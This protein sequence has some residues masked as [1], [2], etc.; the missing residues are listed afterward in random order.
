MNDKVIS[1]CMATYNGDKYIKEQLDS[2]LMQLSENDELIISDDSSNDNTLNIIESLKDS[3]IKVYR[4][5]FRNVVQNFEFAISKSKGD[6]IFLSDQDDIWHPDKVKE[7][8][9]SFENSNANL[10]ISDLQLIDKHGQ[11]IHQ[12]FFKKKFSSSFLRNLLKNEF[13]GC[14][15]AFDKS[16]K[17][18]ILPFPND[19]PMHDWWIGLIS[20]RNFNV[21]FIEKKLLFY[22]RHDNNVSSTKS[23]KLSK[24]VVWRVKLIKNLLLLQ[25]K[26]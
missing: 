13:I 9:K 19:I 16:V 12:E 23:S 26:D 1:V 20:L 2:I 17:N 5:E 4:N 8:L 11:Y 15:I 22:R 10:V 24:V 18:K 3:R 25:L 21:I 6:F 14:S 7:Y